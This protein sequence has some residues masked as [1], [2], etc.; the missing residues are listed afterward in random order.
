MEHNGVFMVEGPINTE[1]AKLLKSHVNLLLN[2]R[3]EVTINIDHVTEIDTTGLSILRQLFEC[4]EKEKQSFDIT[5]YGWKE[6][7]DDFK[8]NYAA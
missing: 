2:Y 3:D 1:T 6:I 5:G 7:Y 8:T 4:S